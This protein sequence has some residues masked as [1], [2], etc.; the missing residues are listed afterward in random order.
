M[1]VVR[2]LYTRRYNMNGLIPNEKQLYLLPYSNRTVSVLLCPTPNKDANF[3][4]DDQKDPFAAPLSRASHVGD[5]NTGRC[6][7]KSHRAVVK[8]KG[9][10]II[11]TSILAMDK[12]HIHLGGRLQME[13]IINS[14]GLLKQS[15]CPLP[16]AMRILG[17]K[18]HSTPCQPHVTVDVAD[19]NTEFNAP[20]GLPKGTVVL[21][22]PMRRMNNLTWSMY[23][24]VLYPL[25]IQ[26][27]RMH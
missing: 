10:D 23:L 5:I 8:K 11:L 27:P 16:I 22:A 25:C 24:L 21:D 26:V 17:Y 14:H 18:N 20:T 13:A 6:Y 4:F 9:V 2:N 3:L 12:T 1:K 7:R 15:V 19:L